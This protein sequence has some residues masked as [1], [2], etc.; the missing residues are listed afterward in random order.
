MKHGI[1]VISGESILHPNL[2]EASFVHST[3]GSQARL[4]VTN[5]GFRTYG[6]DGILDDYVACNLTLTFHN[7]ILKVATLVPRWPGSPT[8]W[9]EWNV[10]KEL[11][12]KEMNDRLLIRYLGPPPYQY[13]WGEVSSVYDAKSGYSAIVFRYFPLN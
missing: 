9:S 11:E 12:Y 6:V 8:E 4:L 7:G 5:E 1:L 13:E 2:E 10:D 3:L